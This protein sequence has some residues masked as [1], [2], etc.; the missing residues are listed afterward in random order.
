MTRRLLA[1]SYKEALTLHSLARWRRR[2]AERQL[3]KSRFVPEPGKRHAG[4]INV[5][6]SR[7]LEERLM[8]FIEGYPEYN[9][10]EWIEDEE[11]T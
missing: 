6:I 3:A 1:V 8:T 10:D 2:K 9:P 5:E 4:E 7:A 11:Q